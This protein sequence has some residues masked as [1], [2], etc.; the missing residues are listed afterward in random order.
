MASERANPETSQSELSRAGKCVQLTQDG[1]GEKLLLQGRVPGV[2]DD[3]R[4]EDRSNTSSRPR[5]SNGGSSGSDE[6]GSRVDVLLSPGGVDE[7]GGL[8]SGGPQA[9]PGSHAEAGRDGQTGNSR[10]DDAGEVEWQKF[11]K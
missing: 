11:Y 6:L 10:H 9:P 5:N 4:P 2:A 8:H 7:A 3:E 1:V